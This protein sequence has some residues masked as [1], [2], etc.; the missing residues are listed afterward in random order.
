MHI[1]IHISLSKINILEYVVSCTVAYL[2]VVS[3]F[4]LHYIHPVASL[5][6]RR[7]ESRPVR[8]VT[9]QPPRRRF[10]GGR[11]RLKQPIE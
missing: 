11:G 2:E 6:T 1:I 9:A 5:F 8:P 10:S 3:L 7:N 4:L